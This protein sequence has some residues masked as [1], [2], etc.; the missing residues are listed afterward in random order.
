VRAL[1]ERLRR[2]SVA[3]EQD[4]SGEIYTVWR[5]H[6]RDAGEIR[7]RLPDLEPALEEYRHN[8]AAIAGFARRAGARVVFASQPVMW[9]ARLDPELRELLWMGGVGAYQREPG[10]AYYSVEA[11]AEGMQ[12]YNRALL[13]TCRE[14]GA[15][16]IDLAA[17]LPRDTRA[18]YDDCHFNEPGARRVAEV[19]ADYL[20]E[21]P[22]ASGSLRAAERPLAFETPLASGS[23]PRLARAAK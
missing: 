20:L 23:P 10:H 13:E 5:R 7:T 6:R 19:L 1:A 22:L 3:S 11:L 2:P 21:T 14:L 9:S 16:C 8:L 12:R 4:E 17:A 18:F 15:D